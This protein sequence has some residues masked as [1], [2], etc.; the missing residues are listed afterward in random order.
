MD[1]FDRRLAR[2]RISTRLRV[3]KYRVLRKRDR[4]KNSPENNNVTVSSNYTSPEE[5]ELSEID[6]FQEQNYF[7]N[8]IQ[9]TDIENNFPLKNETDTLNNDSREDDPLDVSEDEFA[10]SFS[11]SLNSSVD[12]RHEEISSNIIN[13]LREWAFQFPPLPHSR[14]DSLLNILRPILPQLSK[15]S[16]TFLQTTCENYKIK[17]LDEHDNGLF[18]YFGLSSHLIKYLNPDL[19]LNTIKLIINVDGLPLFKSSSTSFWPILCKIFHQ[20]DIY[21]PFPV[22]IYCGIQKP[23]NVEKYFE[24]FI[25]EI[26][27]LQTEGLNVNNKLFQVSVKAFICDRPARSFVKCIKNHNRFWACERCLIRGERYKNRTIYRDGNYE[28]RTDR[29]F[30][31]QTNR[32]HHR[33]I[34]PLI[35]I[36][37][38]ID[39][40]NNF[41]LDAMHLLYLGVMKKLLECWL[42]GTENKQYIK[43]YYHI[44][45]KHN[46]HLC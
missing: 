35:H 36:N 42:E 11:I 5:L 14:L 26:N 32:E 44:I 43:K 8:D 9:S 13:N 3:Q 38:P 31:E 23:G 33:G 41:P 20:P 28:L 18:V 27:L 22:A 12:T 15:S 10:S 16:K 19:H 40:I 24:K 39:M 21:K 7:N 37:P 34:S 25:E 4:N 46:Y 1:L 17:K 30:R 29:S 2:K 6:N 45:Q